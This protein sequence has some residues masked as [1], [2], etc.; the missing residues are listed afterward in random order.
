MT[1]PTGPALGEQRRLV[2]EN[3]CN[4][5]PIPGIMQAFKL[6]QLEV[7]QT[8]AFVSKKIKEYRF[9]RHMP[10]L[11]CDNDFDRRWNR[12]ALLETLR[13]LGDKHMSSELLIPKVE[14]QRLNTTQDLRKAG[15]Q[16]R[17]IK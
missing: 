2:F 1:G 16:V 17:V 6:S 7:E 10:P 5:V 4:G 13:K 12:R 9:R 15:R 11:E 14:I 3:V 8:V